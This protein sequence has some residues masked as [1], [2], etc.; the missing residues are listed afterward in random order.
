MNHP[1]A[2]TRSPAGQI[3]V[4]IGG[5]TYAPWRNNFYPEK[6]VQRCELEYA[7]RQL[8]TIEINGTFYRA[9]KPATYAKWAA[10]TP[11]G[12]MFSL[13]APRYITQAT[14]LANAG[15]G[16]RAFVEGGLAEMGDRLGPIVWQLP[17]S[18]PFD[19][20]DLTVFLELLPPQ[21]N[22][23]P[24]RHVL[25][26][27]D[28]SFLDERYV[29]LAR[30][31][32]VATVFTDAPDFPT[33]A[34]LTSDFVYA[35]LKASIDDVPTG[36]P[37]AALDMWATH[38]RGWA[39]GIDIASLPHAAAVQAPAISRDVF[40]FF[41]GAAKHRNPAAAVALQSRVDE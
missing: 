37:S 33:L 1:D 35:R 34:D 23:Q 31:H 22:G 14:H 41:I 6:L 5:W 29:T 7:S 3:R 28:A 12:F 20:D 9:Q 16:I 8:R 19:L 15:K 4:G 25:E 17:P 36:Y 18:H 38:A 13:K 24:L 27:R 40:V 30:S 2:S 11:A 26:V 21:L 32:R 39:A 10:E